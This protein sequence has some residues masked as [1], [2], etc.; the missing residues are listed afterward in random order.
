M[1]WRYKYNWIEFKFGSN[2][3]VRWCTECVVIAIQPMVVEIFHSKT[4]VLD[5]LADRHFHPAPVAKK[6]YT[7]VGW[8]VFLDVKAIAIKSWLF[9]S[10]SYFTVPEVFLSTEAA[11]FWVTPTK[12]VPSTS[13][14]R[15]F[16]WIL[17]EAV[18]R[19]RIHSNSSSVAFI[20]RRTQTTLHL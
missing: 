17:E 5:Q 19:F 12:L 2:D 18:K 13:T 4:I 8:F 7:G 15:S 1:I 6:H 20:L 16:T 3:G 10:N 11:K 14:I 9:K